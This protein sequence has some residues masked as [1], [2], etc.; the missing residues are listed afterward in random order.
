[1][2]AMKEHQARGKGDERKRNNS[3]ISRMS[4]AQLKPDF[5]NR[6]LHE[7]LQ[8]FAALVLTIAY[9]NP[10]TILRTYNVLL[11]LIYIGL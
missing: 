7:L 2:A 3:V 4:Y 8:L 11:P 10:N 1:M 6:R 9:S 5:P